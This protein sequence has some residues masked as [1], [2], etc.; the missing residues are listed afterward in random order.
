MQHC[1]APSKSSIPT[2]DLL[3]IISEE[4]SVV[5]IIAVD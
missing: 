3:E 1:A 4:T 5:A 2:R